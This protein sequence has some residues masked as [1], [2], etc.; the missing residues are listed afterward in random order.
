MKTRYDL[1]LSSPAQDS[2]DAARP[3]YPDTRSIDFGAIPITVPVLVVEPDDRWAYRPYLYTN[4]Y[5]G[6]SDT[7]AGYDD[8]IFNYNNIPHISKVYDFPT[9][10]LPDSSDMNAFMTKNN[11]TSIR[12]N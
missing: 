1:M 12:A 6:G 5:Y 11:Q 8:I 9:I 4:A 2:G 10:K 7:Y 3:Y